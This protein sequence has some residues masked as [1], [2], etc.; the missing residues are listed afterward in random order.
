MKLVLNSLKLSNKFS[1]LNKE[2]VLKEARES[3]RNAQCSMYQQSK[4][5][6]EELFVEAKEAEILH[7][8]KLNLE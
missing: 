5:V 7:K 3:H 1:I 2:R 6:V 8:L 4:A